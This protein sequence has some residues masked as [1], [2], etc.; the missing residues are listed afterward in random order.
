MTTPGCGIAPEGKP[1]IYLAAFAALLFA[2]LSFPV[3]AC[4]SFCLC[5]FCVYFF[6]DPE[7]VIPE[8][9][10]LCVS[11]A[12]GRVLG[13]RTR[14]DPL[15]GSPRTCISIFMNLLNVHVNRV[16]VDCTVTA[17]RYIPG[18]FMNASFDKASE[19]NERCIWKLADN[20]GETWYMVQIAGLVARRIVCR[21]ACGDTL[22]RG[23]RCG[24]IRF[25][26]RVDLYVPASYHPRVCAG[27]RVVAGQTV[28][29]RR[30]PSTGSE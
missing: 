27:E 3:L 14:N 23:E 17:M 15:D 28:L 18:K 13:I 6:R 11:P 8:G 25:G 29:A 10:G 24:L 20:D 5:A 16:P 2:V 9:E 1:F 7:R 21:A 26:S 30:S 4:V 22:R 19:D 12:D